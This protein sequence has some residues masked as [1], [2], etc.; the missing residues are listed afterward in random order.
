[1]ALD[2]VG[3]QPRG[4]LREGDAV[5]AEAEGVERAIVGFERADVAEAVVCDA[6]RARPCELRLD[7]QAGDQ[8]VE[9]I[10]Q[11]SDFLGDEGVAGLCFDDL[12]I[13]AA[14]EEA[15]VR[16]ACRPS[17]SGRRGKARRVPT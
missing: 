15:A 11:C 5:S 14:E 7:V 9:L 4:D 3:Q 17:S 12:H 10:D 2:V 16:F 6:E 8:A 13:L 1:M